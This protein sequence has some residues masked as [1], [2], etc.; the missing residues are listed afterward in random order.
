MNMPLLK[1]ENTLLAKAGDVAVQ[2]A[3][4]STP[5][6]VASAAK[7]DMFILVD[8]PDRENEGD[9][10]LLADYVTPEAINFMVKYGRGLVCLALDG[11]CATQ[12]GLA[13]APRHN[14]ER[15]HTPFTQSI[16]ARHGITTGISAAD[17]AHTIQ[18][19]VSSQADASH[20]VSPGHIFPLIASDG[21]VLSRPG[22]TEA[23]VDIA[24]LAGAA[25]AAVICEILNDDGTMA[26]LPDLLR[27]SEIHQI[28]IGT[29][30]DLIA[31]RKANV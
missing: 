30:S 14:V 27:F 9:L 1:A 21:G 31:Y 26:R 19:A 18:L 5:E 28:P 17:R 12:L 24:R 20:F 16:D 8:N 13:L 2:H 15:F 6:I 10:I 22:H 3:L 7:G 11:V 4:S 29:I 23:S 25:P